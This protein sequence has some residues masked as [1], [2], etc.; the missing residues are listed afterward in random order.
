[1]DKKEL[2]KWSE[3]AFNKWELPKAITDYYKDTLDDWRTKLIIARLLH[4]CDNVK[5]AFEIITSVLNENMDYKKNKE[6][7]FETF[8][9]YIDNKAWAYKELGVL[10]W[11]LYHDGEKGLEYI[12]EALKISESI[13]DTFLITTRGDIFR[14]KLDIL[15]ALGRE[16]EAINEANS[17]INFIG[18]NIKNSYLY[19]AY[20]FKANCEKEKG[21]YNN[22][23]SYLNEA[24]NV[25]FYGEENILKNKC[26]DIMKRIDISDER[27]FDEIKLILEMS[28]V[29][30]DI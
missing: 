28:D 21:R 18:M 8:I 27:K 5:P 14:E 16:E 3:Y 23:L 11:K 10:Y 4:K 29:S 2:Q 20:D 9:E 7:Y 13:N 26:E 6:G 19:N 30:W 15:K 1:M 12:N 17:K 25:Y 22:A 24:Y